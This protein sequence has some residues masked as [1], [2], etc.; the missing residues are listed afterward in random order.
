MRPSIPEGAKGR[1]GKT[2]RRGRWPTLDD[3]ECHIFRE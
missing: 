3:T 1:F 2:R